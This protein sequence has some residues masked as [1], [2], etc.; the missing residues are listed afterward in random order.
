MGIDAFFISV[1]AYLRARDAWDSNR[2]TAPLKAASDA[3]V[4]DSDG[5]TIEDIVNEISTIAESRWATPVV[6]A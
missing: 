6:Q 1:L 5:R 3:I 4:I 2:E